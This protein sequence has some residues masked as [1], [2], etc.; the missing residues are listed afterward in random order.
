MVSELTTLHTYVYGGDHRSGSD[1]IAGAALGARLVRDS[2]AGG[3]R[4]DHI[5]ASDPDEPG[6]SSPLARPGVPAAGSGSTAAIA[7]MPLTGLVSKIKD[8]SRRPIPERIAYWSELYAGTPYFS[9]REGE[10]EPVGLHLGGVDCETYVEQ[11]MAI[12]LSRHFGEVGKI[13][14]SLRYDGGRVEPRYRHYTVARGWLERTLEINPDLKGVRDNL[15]Y[16]KGR[17]ATIDGRN[18][19]Q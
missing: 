5:Y 1:N 12:S 18:N 3:Y 10:L 6:R 16:A 9:P 7:R 8:L 14:N 4:V 19:T 15:E 17:I 11:V 13:L 2:G